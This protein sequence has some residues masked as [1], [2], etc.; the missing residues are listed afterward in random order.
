MQ[1]LRPRGGVTFNQSY[2]LQVCAPT[3][4]ALLTARYPYTYGMQINDIKG[5]NLVWLNTTL[6]LFPE[7]MKENGYDTY[8]VGKWHLGHCNKTLTPLWRGFDY[9]F[10]FY[11]NALGFFN[12]SGQSPFPNDFPQPD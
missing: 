10:G 4:S 9:D 2:V 6:K 11:T 7:Y 3:R 1:L 12:H 5:A 8:K